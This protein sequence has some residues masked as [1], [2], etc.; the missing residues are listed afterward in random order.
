VSKPDIDAQL[1]AERI[2]DQLEKR[3]SYRR[4]MKKAAE[5]TMKAGAKGVKVRLAG[6]LGGSDMSRTEST[7]IGSL[8]LSS[9]R[10]MIDYGFTEARTSAGNIGVKCW[11]YTGIKVDEP[12]EVPHGADAKAS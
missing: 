10:A 9:L 11:V 12:E 7:H 8:P 4:A 2:A 5:D 3:S 1:I 6:R